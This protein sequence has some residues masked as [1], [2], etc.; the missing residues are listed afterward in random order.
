MI[1]TQLTDVGRKREHN[2]DNVAIAKVELSHSFSRHPFTLGVVCDGM[3]GAAGGE[4]A[5]S[6]AL[7]SMLRGLYTQLVNQTMEHSRCF[8]QLREI[9]R[10]VIQT[11]N[12]NVYNE[13]NTR[14]GFSG[15]GCTSTVM[16]LSRTR[17]F[18]AQVGDSRGYR[19]RQGKLERLT[20]DHSFVAEL[21]RDGRITEEE[22]ESH[23]RKSVITRAIGSRPEVL[24]DIYEFDVRPGDLYLGC[25]DGLSGMIFDP[26]LEEMLSNLGPKPEQ[27]E[28]E[29]CAQA[30]IQGANDNGGTDNISVFLA[31][32]EE[33]D[34]PRTSPRPL[35][36]SGATPS[37][38]LT[39]QEA[40]DLDLEDASFQVLPPRARRF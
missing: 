28:L 9:L 30:L 26:E 6:I 7:E 35:T 1:I 33:E 40:V 14:P 36:V 16:V 29:E 10:N 13:A 18:F 32:V 17:G 8:F 27:E 21:V 19:F 5:S 37:S 31:W 39:W 24:P 15:M 12:F 23:P 25:S 20:H 2:E 4:I 22:A 11:A 34:C 38:V 3:G